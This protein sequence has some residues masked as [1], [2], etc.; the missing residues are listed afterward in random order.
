M[1]Q[2][3]QQTDN[4]AQFGLVAVA[5]G[6]TSAEREVSLSSGDA[7]LKALLR[8][9]VN[10]VGVDIGADPLT[11]LQSRPFDR[12]FNI[13]H[14]RSGEDGVLQGVLETVGLPYTGSGLLA[15]ALSM[16]KRR[17]KLCW[18]GACLPTPKWLL[19][20]EQ[21]DLDLCGEV[22]GFPV[23]VKPTLEGSSIGISQAKNREELN[24]AW[25]N[26]LQ[27]QCDVIAE[28]WITG[29][30][31]TVAI[32]GETT[33]PMIRL[34]TPNLFYDFDA[35]YCADTTQY[36]CP[37]GLPEENERS[38]QAL[39][40]SAYRTLGIEGWG[41]IDLM[42]DAQEAPWLIEANTVPGMTDHSLVPM[43]AQAAGIDFDQLVW[44]I[45]A[46]SLVNRKST[47]NRDND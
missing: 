44:R 13:L 3:T 10:A 16:D 22:L 29:Q 12:V 19:L 24:E 45:L 8:L 14:G 32:L 9:G 30:E 5:M 20:G 26:A 28:Q 42:I 17:S 46:T 40:L 43:A 21:A 18:Q 34:E 4:P 31:Y 41:R 25:H 38:L 1:N 35:K 6:G 7:V 2:T 27:Y 15:S 47:K 37:C 11:T 23:I 33:L 39:A 36:I